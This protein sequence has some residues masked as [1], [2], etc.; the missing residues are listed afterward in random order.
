MK[1]FYVVITLFCSFQIYAS[2]I[3][4]RAIQEHIKKEKD[5]LTYFSDFA[6][7]VISIQNGD[8]EVLAQKK[9][10]KSPN[11]ILHLA[12][13]SKHFTGAAIAKLILEQRIKLDD[14]VADIIPQWPHYARN[15]KVS[16]LLN[17]SSGL[18]EYTY[19]CWK[20]F[21]YT[22]KY[23]FD[24]FVKK[25]NHL[26][27]NPGSKYNYSNTG[28]VMLARIV[29]VISGKN[30]PKYMKDKFF[31]PLNMNDTLIRGYEQKV[32]SNIKTVYSKNGLWPIPQINCSYV[33]GDGG[34][35]TNLK[36][37]KKWAKFLLGQSVLGN[38]IPNLL[39]SP[40]GNSN[41]RYGFGMNLN[42][43]NSSSIKY[44]E[45]GGI[46]LGTKTGIAIFPEQ[47][48]AILLLGN[49]KTFKSD[50]LRKKIA[51]EIK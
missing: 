17:H 31:K 38:E 8:I 2:S 50:N 41:N 26:K 23:I 6:A 32:P 19:D 37:F 3:S 11:D 4:K 29:E 43:N 39:F 27:F 14:Y 35:Y 12:S 46:W 9:F 45:H 20:M 21:D 49:S 44:H 5:S 7:S 30:F 42:L 24:S 34:V 51:N 18:L 25:Q 13:V 16:H 10:S 36:D 15:I 1:H 28:Y 48:I 22:P 47:N 40:S 33:P